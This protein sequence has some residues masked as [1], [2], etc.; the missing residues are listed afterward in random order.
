M[1]LAEDIP[2]AGV[3]V[4]LMVQVVQVHGV[5]SRAISQEAEYDHYWQAY[6]WFMSEETLRNSL[7]Q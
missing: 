6:N 7:F 1:T 2:L 5:S 3:E 4:G